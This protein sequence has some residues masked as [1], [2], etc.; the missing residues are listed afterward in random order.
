MIVSDKSLLKGSAK[1]AYLNIK[2]LYSNIPRDMRLHMYRVAEYAQI[3]LQQARKSGVWDDSLPRDILTYSKEIFQLHDI[4]RHYI[5]V[6]VYNKV[7]K[8]TV[9]EREEL[10]RHTVY[11]LQAEKSVFRA[12][13][14]EHIM[15]YFRQV[16]V[17]HHERIDGKG[18]PY[19][20]KGEE[21]PFLAKVCAI[22]DAY[23]GMVSWKPYKESMTAGRALEVLKSESGKQFQP[24]LVECFV[25]CREEIE[26]INRKMNGND[27][28]EA[29]S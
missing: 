12:F 29:S 16:A 25:A 18:Y 3:L 9:E 13:F 28:K 17:L 5:S 1:G 15:P 7:E 2:C 23:D 19:G 14:P 24:E 11:A 10:K 6:D 4:G 21:I 20:K 22:A 8:L 27:K 26:Q